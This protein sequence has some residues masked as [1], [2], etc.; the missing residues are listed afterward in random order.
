MPPPDV[1]LEALMSIGKRAL[2]VVP[3]T[4]FAITLVGLG[5]GAV[6]GRPVTAGPL[7]GGGGDDRRRASGNPAGTDH[8]PRTRP[9]V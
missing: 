2:F 7:R 3:L 8:L 5:P 4:L 6:A 1:F 9:G